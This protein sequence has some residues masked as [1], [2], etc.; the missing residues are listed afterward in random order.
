[1]NFTKRERLRQNEL[2]R[3]RMAARSAAFTALPWHEQK[4]LA[5]QIVAAAFVDH[6]TRHRIRIGVLHDLKGEYP[7]VGDTDHR[8]RNLYACTFQRD[9]S[10]AAE[11]WTLRALS[12]GYVVLY[13][14]AGQ[15]RGTPT[16]QPA[17]AG[18]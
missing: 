12:M 7:E 3:E 11:C 6:G 13:R 1:M 10:Y 15:W 14:S 2:V 4:R 18:G 9:Q 17:T 5:R 8:D 16:R